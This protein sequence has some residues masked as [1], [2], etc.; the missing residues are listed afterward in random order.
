MPQSIIYKQSNGVVAV[1]RPTDEAMLKYGINAIANKDVPSGK[2]YKIILSTDI[3]VDRAQRDQ[4]TVSDA[5]LTDGVGS[6]SNEFG[7]I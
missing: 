1:I 7:V 5:D 2:P 6:V 3:P 4:W